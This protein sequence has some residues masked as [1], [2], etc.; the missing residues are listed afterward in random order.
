MIFIINTK[1][2]NFMNKLFEIRIHAKYNKKRIF[3]HE[4]TKI[5]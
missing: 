3:I 2:K 4:T 5:K 1:K